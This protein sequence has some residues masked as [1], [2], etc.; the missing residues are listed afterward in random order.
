MTLNEYLEQ[1]PPGGRAILAGDL[2]I[3]TIYLKQLAARQNEREP[4]AELCVRIE[5]RVQLVTRRDLRPDDWHLIWPELITRNH[6]A[7][8][9]PAAALPGPVA[10]DEDRS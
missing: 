2:G 9:E 7:P 8:S 6:P 4:S 5:R 10:A 3:S 1:L